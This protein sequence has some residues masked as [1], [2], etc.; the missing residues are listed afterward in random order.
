MSVLQPSRCPVSTS[1]VS[2]CFTRKSFNK[3]ERGCLID[4]KQQ[5]NCLDDS[6]CEMCIADGE[7][8][9]NH[10]YADLLQS[11]SKR[12]SASSVF[13]L[14]YCLTLASFELY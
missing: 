14:T 7:D 5:L 2:Y 1:V 3:I 13:L 12:V 4:T 8:T 6:S 9:C 10:E 11:S